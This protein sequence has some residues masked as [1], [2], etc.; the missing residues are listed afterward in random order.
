M[1][2]LQITIR[3]GG[4][5]AQLRNM[6]RE[7]ESDDLNLLDIIAGLTQAEKEEVQYELI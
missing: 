4:T 2:A 3:V 7:L 6:K 5:P 1:Q